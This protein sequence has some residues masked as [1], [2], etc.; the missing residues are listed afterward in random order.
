MFI[1]DLDLKLLRQLGWEPK[2]ELEYSGRYYLDW[3]T[4][5]RVLIAKFIGASRLARNFEK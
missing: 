3:L 1:T 2:V 4:E 5:N